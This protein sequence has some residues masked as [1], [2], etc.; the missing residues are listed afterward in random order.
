[1]VISLGHGDFATFIGKF[2]NFFTP[3]NPNLSLSFH[4]FS[5]FRRLQSAEPGSTLATLETGCGEDFA[6]ASQLVSTVVFVFCFLH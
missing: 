5:P 2:S 4:S 1:M 3:F 6:F